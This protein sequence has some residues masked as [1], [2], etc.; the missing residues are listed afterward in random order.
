MPFGNPVSF[1]T[2]SDLMTK[3][4]PASRLSS[5]LRPLQMNVISNI[6]VRDNISLVMP[7]VHIMTQQIVNIIFLH[8]EYFFS[9]IQAGDRPVPD[10]GKR[11]GRTP[12]SPA[13]SV[14]TWPIGMPPVC[15][16]WIPIS[17]RKGSWR[18]RDMPGISTCTSTPLW[19]RIRSKREAMEARHGQSAAMP[20]PEISSSF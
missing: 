14:K 2:R 13:Q 20:C 3:P 4:T 8:I 7:Y 5:L 11:I 6:K 1:L 9:D 16:G 18:L 19:P 15:R 10:P 17:R 12:P